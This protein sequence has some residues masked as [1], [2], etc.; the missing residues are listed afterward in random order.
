[1]DNSELSFIQKKDLTNNFMKFLSLYKTNNIKDLLELHMSLTGDG[2]AT[3][4]KGG[5]SDSHVDS[6]AYEIDNK[7]ST[8]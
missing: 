3:A 8:E 7:M 1:M 5:D 4:S 2:D 6:S